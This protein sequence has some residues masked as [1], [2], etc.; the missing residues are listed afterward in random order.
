MTARVVV[1]GSLNHDITVWVPRRPNPDETLHGDRIAEFRGGKGANQAVAAARLEADVSMV[2]A[3]GADARGTFLL[4][5]LDA[6]GI[7][8][9][10]VDRVDTPTGVALITVDPTDVSIIVVAGANGTV[11]EDVANAACDSIAAADV[12]LLQGEIPAAA[13][14]RAAQIAR[15]HRTLVVFNPAPVNEVAA[16]VLELTDVLVVN[17]GEAASIGPV[18]TDL[19]VTTL[20]AEGCVVSENGYA[21][22]I[23]P[24]EADMVDPTG[25]G[26]CFVAALA[27]SL[28]EGSEPVDAARFASA[29]GSLAVESE[30]AQ[31]S[32]PSRSAVE[33][34]LG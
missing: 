28:A 26:D 4:D 10:L 22:R 29:A 13:A 2:G 12:L 31:P 30:G 8:H 21:T 1:V 20:G 3:V 33:A 19:V 9:S 27:V 5:G 24:F 25:A 16:A 32:L 7:D 34:R 6:E 18:D 14:R 15:E 17:R 11:G 23:E